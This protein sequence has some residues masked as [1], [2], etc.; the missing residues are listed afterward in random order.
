MIIKPNPSLGVPIYLQLVH[1]V[2]HAVET[3][4]LRDVLFGR[5]EAGGQ[6][7]HRFVEALLR[8]EDADLPALFAAG[9]D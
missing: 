7:F 9:V 2:K 1:Q 3:G 4:A 6:R 8:C 5:N